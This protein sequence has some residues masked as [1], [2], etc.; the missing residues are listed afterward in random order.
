MQ[1]IDVVGTFGLTL[2]E[3][4]LA[5]NTAK[6][7]LE[8]H[9][10]SGAVNILL[11]RI[12][13]P[14]GTSLKNWWFEIYV[15]DADNNA[16]VNNIKVTPNPADTI[17][18]LSIPL[19]IGTNGGTALLCVVGTSN[20]FSAMSVGSGGVAIQK[21][22]TVKYS[23][24][25]PNATNL[26]SFLMDSLSKGIIPFSGKVKE[27]IPFTSSGTDN[28]AVP[29]FTV[30]ADYPNAAFITILTSEINLF[31]PLNPYVGAWD[32]F[33]SKQ[34]IPVHDAP[35]PLY[36]NILVDDGFGTGVINNLNGGE[37]EMWITFTQMI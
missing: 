11:P 31:D 4:I 24:F 33:T 36:A 28:F 34:L 6:I 32:T 1:Y 25:Q 22:Y 13:N 2:G 12:T 8:C 5:M 14:S 15:N 27:S 10:N 19:V 7:Y 26:G 21:K 9:T 30:N 35:V 18:G 3:D 37:F 16:S 23:D 29:F 20:W 17:D